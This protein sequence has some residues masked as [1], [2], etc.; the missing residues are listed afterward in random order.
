MNHLP[1]RNTMHLGCSCHALNG[2]GLTK[3]QVEAFFIGPNKY[4]R[5]TK[6]TNIYVKPGEAAFRTI[7]PNENM[8]MVKGINQAGTWGQLDSGYWIWLEDSMYTVNLTTP[9]PN[10]LFDAVGREVKELSVNVLELVG[11]ILLKAGIGVAVAF[12]V[13]QLGKS[14]ITSKAKKVATA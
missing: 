3:A 10:S 4:V 12:G 8:G 14:Y 2:L 9:P 5:N 13:Y 6:A 1:L 11:P 7:G